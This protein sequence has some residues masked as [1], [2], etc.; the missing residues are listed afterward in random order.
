MSDNHYELGILGGMGPEATSD[1]Y[2]RI[3]NHTKASSDQ[4]HIKMVILNNCDTPDR[5]KALLGDGP[6]PLPALNHGIQTLSSLG[7][8]YF[9]IP[10]NTAHA[11]SDKFWKRTKMQFISM[12]DTVIEEL[13][14]N[15]S[16]KKI[17]VLCT[18]GSRDAGIYENKG[19]EINYPA[20]QDK[21]MSVI[22][23]TKAGIYDLNTLQEV[24]TEEEKNYDVFILACTELSLYKDKLETSGVILDAMDILVKSIIIKCE[25]KYID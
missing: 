16:D 5:T 6:S 17:C 21:V 11:Y 18:N 9:V 12:I 22:T 7:C 15:Y 23:N 10:C 8:K 1:L 20:S 19:I 24:I 25:H 13:K 4:D 14:E 2:K 3:I